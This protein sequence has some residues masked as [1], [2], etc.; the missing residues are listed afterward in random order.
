MAN[1]TT[2][3]LS[4]LLDASVCRNDGHGEAGGLGSGCSSRRERSG[5]AGGGGERADGSA[6]TIAQQLQQ[7]QTINQTQIETMEANTQALTQNTSSKGTSARIDG[8]LGGQHALRRLG[9]GLGLSPLISG[10]VSLFGGGESSQ[11]RR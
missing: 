7:L 3:K 5:G 2:N 4:I 11:P 10:L 6:D 8:E 1:N 9:L